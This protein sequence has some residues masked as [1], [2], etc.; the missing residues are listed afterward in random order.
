M[1]PATNEQFRNE[2][3][4]CLALVAPVG[5]TEEAKRDWLRVAW[6]TLKHLPP[7]ILARGCKTARETCDHPSKIV[8]AVLAAT[9]LLMRWRRDSVRGEEPER[10]PAPDYCTPEQASAILEEFGLKRG[11]SE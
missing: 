5:M 2:L 6:A 7:D 11:R 3:T 9:E 8:P 10:L 4:A 1:V